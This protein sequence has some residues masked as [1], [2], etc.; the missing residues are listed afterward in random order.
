ML[1]SQHAQRKKCLACWK[2]TTSPLIRKVVDVLSDSNILALE[3]IIS[4]MWDEMF[5]KYIDSLW[6][7]GIVFATHP[8]TSILWWRLTWVRDGIWEKKFENTF[9]FFIWFI[10]KWI[11]IPIGMAMEVISKFYWPSKRKLVN[12]PRGAVKDREYLTDSQYL[13][14]HDLIKYKL[15]LDRAELD[16]DTDEDV[17]YFLLDNDI[18]EMEMITFLQFKDKTNPRNIPIL[19]KLEKK[20]ETS[21]F[22]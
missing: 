9:P 7:A 15:R 20:K 16:V 4:I 1:H 21:S 14:I 3:T 13:R 10:K 2:V 18:P 19:L 5:G 8:P 17:M 22:L 11:P 6:D 12:N